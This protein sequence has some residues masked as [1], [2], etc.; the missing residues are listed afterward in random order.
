MKASS[1]F[2]MLRDVAGVNP[3]RF[4][5]QYLMTVVNG[6]SAALLAYAMDRVFSQVLFFGAGSGSVSG[7][8]KTIGLLLLL[9]IVSEISMG[10]SIYMSQTYDTM[11]LQRIQRQVH[12]KVN[13]FPT[14]RFEDPAFLNRVESAYNGAPSVRR[15]VHYI[16]EI[17]TFYVP[18]FSIYGVYL[19]TLRPA[20]L[21]ALPMM[22]L[23]ILIA[24]WL[25]GKVYSDLA[26]QCAPLRRKKER[27]AAYVSD[28]QFVKETRLLGAVRRFLETYLGAQT[29]LNQILTGSK[30]RGLRL[31]T[32]SKL[33]S[34]VGYLGI[35]GILIDSVLRGRISVS[36]FAA[37][38]ASVSTVIEYGN[39]LIG[40][41]LSELT[42]EWGYLK[43][44]LDLMDE[45]VTLTG[46][47]PK[48]PGSIRLEHVSFAY[49]GGENRQ[50][51]S[52]ICLTIPQGETVAL[53]GEN[54]S[55][56]TT[57][58]KLLL[59]LYEPTGGT[60]YRG[61]V[62]SGTLHSGK[63]LRRHS[64]VFQQ[65]GRYGLTLLENVCLDSRRERAGQAAEALGRAGLS[66]D[67]E[68]FPQGGGTLLSKE[69]GGVDLSGGQWQRIAIARGTLKE[70]ELL[71]LDEPTSAIDPMQEHRIYQTFLDASK[72]KTA[73][74][75]T[76]RLGLARCC[77]RIVVLKAGE[78]AAVGTHEQLLET[79]PDYLRQWN[80][81]AE[82]Y[83]S[84]VIFGK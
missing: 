42:E 6:V 80:A 32:A 39:E 67:Q 10:C 60:L 11:A 47:E 65:F 69:F 76:H 61:G 78:I 30:R 28:R 37:V 72:G 70:S 5:C 13:A 66:V 63:L 50:V 12:R 82:E 59:G 20:L 31:D 51:L 40:E 43:A 55:G 46:E 62:P 68:T 2:K 84:S 4:G 22:F 56:K 45:D 71:V 1:F 53:V 52:D 58:S 81:Q 19:Y 83:R 35:L 34:L 26:E 17:A 7:I 9:Y 44:Y 25:K 27:C 54:G 14:I 24:Q 21:L 16:M 79:S 18:Y 41:K 73:V 23:P 8:L 77:D 3:R 75:I 74:I 33:I 29:E 49:P 48:E 15:V 57:L 36:S 64:A 38:F